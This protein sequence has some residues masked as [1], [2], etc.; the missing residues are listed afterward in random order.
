MVSQLADAGQVKVY[1]SGSALDGGPAMYLHDPSQHHHVDFREI[2]AFTPFDGTA[3][4]RVAVT[5]TTTGADLLVSGVSAQGVA[6]VQKY[7]F[8]RADPK[9]TTLQPVKLGEIAAAAPGGAV[10]AMLAGD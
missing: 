3:G 4:T 7:D 6:S 8:A 9:A 10:P 2:A 5:A 1:S